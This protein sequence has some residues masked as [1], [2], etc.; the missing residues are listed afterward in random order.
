[1]A[2]KAYEVSG[3]FKLNIFILETKQLNSVNFHRV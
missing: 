1:M 3:N 2:C